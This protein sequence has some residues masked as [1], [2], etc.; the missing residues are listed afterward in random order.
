[1]PE[2]LDN[3]KIAD[4]R[5]RICE[6]AT[7]QFA[8]HG[9]DKVSMRS[10]AKELGYSATALYSYYR[11]KEEILAATRAAALERLVPRLQAAVDGCDQPRDQLLAL[12]GAYLEFSANEPAAYQLIFSPGQEA[13]STELDVATDRVRRIFTACVERLLH[14]Q[15]FSVDAGL[16]GQAFWSARCRR[17]ENGR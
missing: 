2:A 13:N 14:Q 6:V 11:N 10:L 1:M 7:R 17:P 4:F 15:G 8:H 9:A 12:G 3:K 5:R 16:H